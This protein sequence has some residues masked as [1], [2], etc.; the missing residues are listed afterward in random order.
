[1]YNLK[2]VKKLSTNYMVTH[3]KLFVDHIVEAGENVVWVNRE[4]KYK[5]TLKFSNKAWW[6][7]IKHLIF[8]TVNDNI[9]AAVN[10][11]LVSSFMAVLQLNIPC[12]IVEVI[13]NRVL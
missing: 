10:A 1:M 2:K 13:Q 9:L 8:P 5:Y 4:N 3:Y 11:C 7:M 6:L 12:I